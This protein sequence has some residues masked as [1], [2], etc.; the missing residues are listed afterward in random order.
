MGGAGRGGPCVHHR[1]HAPHRH[2]SLWTQ[3]L[4]DDGDLGDARRHSW[5][6][7][8]HAGLRA[9]LASGRQDRL[10][11]IAGDRL[12]T[13]DASRAGIRPAGGSQPEESIASRCFGGWS[14]PR[15]TSDPGRARRR[16]SSAS[17]ADDGGRRQAGPAQRR[18]RKAG[19]PGRAPFCKWNGPSSL[20]HACL[21]EAS[22]PGAD[23]APN[24]N[25]NTSRSNEAMD[26]TEVF[27][28]AFASV[29]PHSI[30]KAEKKGRTKEEVHA[31]IHWLTGYDEQTLQQQIDKKVD[32]ETFFARAPRINPNVS[33][34]T[35]LI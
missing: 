23:R 35:G 25:R 7:A 24:E 6:D 3:E 34:I 21:I 22:H 10:F 13:E 30:T 28:V 4:R 29:Y 26:K 12:Y 16:V 19:S 31:I 33:K 27:R 9:D 17:C 1:S 11:Q 18:M 14:E 32:F 8:W 15:R 20:S 2:I 5:P